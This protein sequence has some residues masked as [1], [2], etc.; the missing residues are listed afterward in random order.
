[1]I[2]LL[3]GEAEKERG[4]SRGCC[5]CVD[6]VSVLAGGRDSVWRTGYYAGLITRNFE[7]DRRLRVLSCVRTTREYSLQ[8]VATARIGM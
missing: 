1:M 4:A 6:S 5:C 7:A 8:T 3:R 2:L